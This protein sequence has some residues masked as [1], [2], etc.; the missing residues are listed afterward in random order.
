MPPNPS[1][2]GVVQTEIPLVDF[3][4]TAVLGN[5]CSND[6]IKVSLPTDSLSIK[7]TNNFLQPKEGDAHL[8][9][10]DITLPGARHTSVA[11]GWWAEG[12]GGELSLT[13]H[14]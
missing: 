11:S 2:P 3:V 5:Y 7:S 1:L 8:Q 4:S 12:E 13:S 6:A 14:R 9:N 10:D